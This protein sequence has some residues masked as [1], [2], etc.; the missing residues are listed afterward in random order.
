MFRVIVGLFV[1]LLFFVAPATAD[2]EG[3]YA[4]IEF[5]TVDKDGTESVFGTSSWDC[6]SGNDMYDTYYR[7]RENGYGIMGGTYAG[8]EDV[9]FEMPLY[10]RLLKQGKRIVLQG[11]IKA[12]NVENNRITDGTREIVYQDIEYNKAV[13]F[14]IDSFENDKPIG[15][16]L[17]LVDKKPA[18]VIADGPISLRTKFVNVSDVFGYHTSSRGKI[19]KKVDFET[20]TGKKRDD[21]TFEKA[22]ILT[23]ILLPGYPDQL[24]APF[25]TELLFKR[26]YKIDTSFVSDREFKADITYHS[27]YKKQVKLVPGKTLMLVFP[28]DTPSVRGYDRED[29]LMLKP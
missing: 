25:A 13:D 29:T 6:G 28:A 14:R 24:T 1:V 10:F 4:V 7:S 9:I 18:P 11:A 2:F 21:G 22:R 26:I 19:E 20:S 5:Y 16:R 17:T 23:E 12:Y 8:D 27:E 3:S 15:L